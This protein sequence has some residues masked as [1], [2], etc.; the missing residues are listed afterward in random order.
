V[1]FTEAELESLEAESSNNIDLKEFIPLA[2]IDP[3][4]FDSAHY[5]GVGEGGDKPYRLLS[6]GGAGESGRLNCFTD[7]DV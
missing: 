4:Y 6:G 7:W 1:Q 5:L 2:T 3:V